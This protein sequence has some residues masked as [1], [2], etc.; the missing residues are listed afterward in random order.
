MK[1]IIKVRIVLGI[2]ICFLLYILFSLY[3]SKYILITSDYSV[4]GESGSSS[5]RIVQVTDLHNSEFGSD[6][7]RLISKVKEQQPD[8]IVLT[9]DLI[10]YDELDISVATNLIQ[11]LNGI[12]P[13]Y[14]S[15]GNHE[16]DYEKVTDTNLKEVFE[17][18]GA[19]VLEEEYVD[20]QIK[21]QNIRIGGVYG[22]CL[23]AEYS[24]WDGYDKGE[25]NFL[26]D[27][28]NTDNYKILLS[29]LP[30]PWLE[31]GFTKSWDFDCI[32]TGHLH[33]GQVRLPF[34]GGVYAPEFGWFPGKLEGIYEKD[35]TSVVLSRGLGSYGAVPRFNNIPEI[36]V[37]DLVGE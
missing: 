12:A 31:Y 3:L 19:V 11:N 36:V 22:Y 2:L 32:F 35:Q 7:I 24:S 26:N 13:V 15:Y 14:F 5:I 16:L 18:A 4:I 6:N 8:L 37:V 28:Q 27:F 1:K 34:I 33:G 9:G 20:I 17:D 29:H 21:N 10:N 25:C 30:T 23:P